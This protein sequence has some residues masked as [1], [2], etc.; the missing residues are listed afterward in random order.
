MASLVKVVHVVVVDVIVAAP[1]VGSRRYLHRAVVL[2]LDDLAKGLVGDW[3]MHHVVLGCH[4]WLVASVRIHRQIEFAPEKL[5]LLLF[6]S[7]ARLSVHLGRMTE[8]WQLPMLL[9]SSLTCHVDSA[10]SNRHSFDLV[11]DHVD[12]MWQSSGARHVAVIGLC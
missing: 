3:K 1:P 7:E 11:V 2:M 4:L 9:S 10:I 5:G 12:G 6:L 8:I